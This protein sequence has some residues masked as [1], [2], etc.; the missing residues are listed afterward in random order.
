MITADPIHPKIS[1]VGYLYTR[2]YYESIRDHLEPGGV[3]CQWMPIYQIAPSRLRSAIKT[4]VEVFPDAT[5]WYVEGHT[6][7]LARPGFPRIDYMLVAQRF[8]DP[9]VREDLASIDIHSPEELLSHLVLGPDE[10]R[11]FLD[12]EP[13][14][15][16]NTDDY[17]YLEYYVPGDLFVPS[18]DN[19]RAF[20]PYLANPARWVD[21]LPAA[22]I[23]KLDAL[24]EARRRSILERTDDR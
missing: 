14:V 1:R 9:R 8:E 18:L 4:F 5:L 17:P 11:A 19:V 21:R 20:V 23:S 22:S 16:L 15:P 12:A 10:I 13:G 7:L 2:E 3:V 6:L 24:S